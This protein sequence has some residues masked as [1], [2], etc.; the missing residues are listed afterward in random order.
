MN[1][2]EIF[3]TTRNEMNQLLNEMTRD[4]VPYAQKGIERYF[5]F[6]AAL[7][8]LPEISK[9][10]VNINDENISEN[11][12]KIPLSN[13]KVE[14]DEMEKQ[15]PEKLYTF[16]R[17]IRGGLI[18]GLDG[19]Y[20]VPEKMVKD[21]GLGHLDKLRI[22]EKVEAEPRNKY[23][24]EIAVAANKKLEGREEYTFCPIEHDNELGLVIK[25]SGQ[26][27]I[28]INEISF[29]FVVMNERDISIYSLQEGDIVD[30]AFY[31]NNPNRSVRVINKHEI[32]AFETHTYKASDVLNKAK[33]IKRS[34]LQNQV[35]EQKQ[36]PIDLD[37]L[38][39]KKILIVGGATRHP[40]YLEALT[41]IGLGE[42]VE[43]ASGDKDKQ[44][45]RIEAMIQKSDIVAIMISECSHAISTLTVGYCKK[46]NVSFSSGH[47][48]GVQAML[49]ALEDAAN[50]YKSKQELA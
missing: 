2:E 25:K 43:F 45:I 30:I 28:K 41:L 5:N 35:K 23:K 22:V 7:N 19:D 12:I 20:L 10:E 4:K 44:H 13:Q 1:K 36:Y 21:A 16:E 24:F 47:S 15:K 31:N 50:K 46:H 17:K 29:T 42:N 27:N 6:L 33:T 32:E 26:D 18:L 3:N 34:K 48:S 8:D 11:D 39:D 37:L 49:L 38:K 14:E 40:D 9:I